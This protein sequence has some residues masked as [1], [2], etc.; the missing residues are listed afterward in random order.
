MDVL[1]VVPV[2]S[3]TGAPC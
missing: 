1:D 3:W 2:L